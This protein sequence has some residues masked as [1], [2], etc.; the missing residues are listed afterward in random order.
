MNSLIIECQDTPNPN[1]VKFYPVGLIVSEDQV[2]EFNKEC[3]DVNSALAR[4]ILD[5]DYVAA[6]VY[7]YDFFP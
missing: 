2:I 3:R 5:L 1:T 7:G 6:V 4:D